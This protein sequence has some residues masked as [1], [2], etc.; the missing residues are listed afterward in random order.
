MNPRDLV[1]SH[2]H[3]PAMA[4]RGLD[5]DG[6][7]EMF[8]PESGGCLGLEIGLGIEGFED[9]RALADRHPG[10]HLTAGLLPEYARTFTGGDDPGLVELVRQ[11][12]DPAV[13]A[14]GEIGLDWFHDY[15]SHETQI[16]LFERQ[17]D[18][19]AS[20]GLPV[21]IHNREADR[22]VLECLDRYPPAAGGIAHCFSSSS[23]TARAFLDRGLL[24]SFAGN[25]TYPGSTELRQAAAAVPADGLLLETDAPYLAP[26]PV[27]GQ[28]NRPRFV[29]H[30]Y[31]CI[32]EVRGVCPEVLAATVASNFRRIL[33]HWRAP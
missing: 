2:F 18:I 32:A 17:L 5:L 20:H 10:L 9:R 6:E 23:Q 3:A 29:I 19:A 14:V 30:T 24:I 28:I 11:I 12:Q 13:V 8:S 4:R 22:D 1:D 31:R 21:V 27:R 25:V 26:Q 16:D 33:N 15:G 7:L